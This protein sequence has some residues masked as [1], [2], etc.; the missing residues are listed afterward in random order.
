MRPRVACAYG[1]LLILSASVCGQITVDATVPIRKRV[2][3]TMAG[4]GSGTGRRL[5]VK[6]AIEVY[7]YPIASERTRV[8]FVL[9]NSG[10]EDIILPVSPHPGDFEPTDPKSSYAVKL[11][12]LYVTS[13]KNH[14]T[15]LP[16]GA[17]L[18]GNRAFPDSLVRLGPGDSMRVLTRVALPTKGEAFV[19]DIMLIDQSVK[20]VGG[21]GLTETNLVGSA[22]SQ[23]YTLQSLLNPAK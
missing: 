8:D 20:I 4:R 23:E 14:R 22:T 16:G 15:L 18:Y 13:D 10:K 9:T 11:L 19:A 2:R 21:E 3:E 7:G 5:P 12:N 1:L 6:V 17:D